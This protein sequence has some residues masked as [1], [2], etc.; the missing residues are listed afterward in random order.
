MRINRRLA[1]ALPV[2][3]LNMSV[4]ADLNNLKNQGAMSTL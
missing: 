1:G 3:D 4:R 2:K